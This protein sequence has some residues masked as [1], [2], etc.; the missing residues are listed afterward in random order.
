MSKLINKKICMDIQ[1]E[2]LARVMLLSILF[3]S[4]EDTV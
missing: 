4:S 1:Q 3:I 2:P